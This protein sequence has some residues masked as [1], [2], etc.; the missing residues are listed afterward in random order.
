MKSMMDKLELSNI[1]KRIIKRA[2]SPLDILF[3]VISFLFIS[4]AFIEIVCM[5]FCL[6]KTPD[7]MFHYIFAMKY[8]VMIWVT[9][10]ILFAS[11]IFIW[12]KHKIKALIFFFS[13]Y[14]GTKQSYWILLVLSF[15]LNSCSYVLHL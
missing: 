15:V 6:I 9:S 10:I 7:G 4:I 1:K 2:L 5:L 3:L 8:E 12:L 11:T 14:K 13:P